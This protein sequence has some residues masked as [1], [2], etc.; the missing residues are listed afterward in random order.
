MI[1]NFKA[2]LT[3]VYNVDYIRFSAFAYY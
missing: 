2:M 1:I 3:R